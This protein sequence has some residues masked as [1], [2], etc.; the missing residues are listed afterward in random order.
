MAIMSILLQEAS[1][2]KFV[3]LGTLVSG[4]I[5]FDMEVKIFVMDE[6]VWAFRKDKYKDLKI[7]TT[8]PGFE[9]SLLKG[10]ENGTVNVWYDQLAELKEMGGVTINLCQLCCAIDNLEKD[11]F[12]DIVDRVASIATY[13]DDIFNADKVV[14]L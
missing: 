11:D 5:V 7:D 12:L 2:N 6:A 3:S 13:M 9:E 14:C 1:L 4:A 10:I 8:V